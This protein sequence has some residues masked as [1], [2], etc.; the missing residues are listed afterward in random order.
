[1]IFFLENTSCI[2][3]PQVISG[4]VCTPCTL[5]LDPSLVFERHNPQSQYWSYNLSWSQLIFTP[6]SSVVGNLWPSFLSNS[7]GE[8]GRDTLKVFRWGW[9]PLRLWIPNTLNQIKFSFILQPKK[10]LLLIPDSL[11][12]R[13]LGLPQ[14]SQIKISF[15]DNNNY[16][17]HSI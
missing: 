8:G 9:L 17:N 12:L 13:N 5:P 14:S 2:R 10:S 11:F 4:G 3:K 6:S 15:Y 1:M 7:P 16:C